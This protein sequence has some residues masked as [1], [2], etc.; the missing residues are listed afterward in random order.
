MFPQSEV[1]VSGSV[2]LHLPFA[3]DP[4]TSVWAAAFP[5]A[6]EYGWSTSAC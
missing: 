5:L 3:G 1:T 4:F 6:A 2:H